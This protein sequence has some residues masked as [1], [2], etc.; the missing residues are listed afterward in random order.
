MVQLAKWC[1]EGNLVEV[2]ACRL[3][4]GEN[5]FKEVLDAKC[6][7]PVNKSCLTDC[8]TDR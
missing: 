4:K 5:V 2:K 8:P 6:L 7:F 1:A 3:A